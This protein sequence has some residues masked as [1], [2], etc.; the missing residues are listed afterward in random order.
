M[1]ANCFK[2]IES[3]LERYQCLRGH[4]D[5]GPALLGLVYPLTSEVNGYT[6]RLCA[7]LATSSPS[8]FPFYRHIFLPR[9]SHVNV[10]RPSRTPVTFKNFT[11]VEFRSVTSIMYQSATKPVLQITVHELH[12]LRTETCITTACLH[13][14]CNFLN[15]GLRGRRCSGISGEHSTK[16]LPKPRGS[17][18]R[19]STS[20]QWY[21]WGPVR[22][23]PSIIDPRALTTYSG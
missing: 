3:H 10:S 1:G 6:S 22:R 11:L 12:V 4:R 5:L 9:R 19:I 7:L 21:L 17:C 23:Q 15:H 20:P 13:A 14:S 18:W 2:K 8:R 16:G